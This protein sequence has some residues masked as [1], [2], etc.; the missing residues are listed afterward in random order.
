MISSDD[1]KHLAA[2]ARIKLA[3][4]EG[5]SL[6]GD[7][8]RILGYVAELSRG[9]SVARVVPLALPMPHQP[10][11]DDGG[12]PV[13]LGGDAA[14]AAFPREADGYCVVPSVFGVEAPRL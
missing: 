13:P 5:E 3:P 10:A 6:R 12:G 14:R 4:G 9:V 8:D 2:L 1:V 7:L 11:R